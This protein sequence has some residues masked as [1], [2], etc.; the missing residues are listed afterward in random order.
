MLG[1]AKVMGYENLVEARAKRAEKY[2]RKI[3]EKQR[4]KRS[5][6]QEVPNAMLQVPLIAAGRI[7]QWPAVDG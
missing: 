2:A 1:K 7:S 4:R 5:G 6:G 3:A